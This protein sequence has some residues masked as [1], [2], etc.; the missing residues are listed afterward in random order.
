[1]EENEL[2]EE[3][4][5]VELT[6]SICGRPVA[7]LKYDSTCSA[8]GFEY[9]LPPVDGMNFLLVKTLETHAL[10]LD[11]IQNQIHATSIELVN[12]KKHTAELQDQVERLYEKLGEI[13]ES[14]DGVRGLIKTLQPLVKQT[15]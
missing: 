6:C 9:A 1:M 15:R 11:E 5:L 12:E 13:T 3:I 8:C 10:K 4:S 2:L 14:V 7:H